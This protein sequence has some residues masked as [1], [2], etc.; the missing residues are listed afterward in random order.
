MK[1]IM[2]S[3]VVGAVLGAVAVMSDDT[4]SMD[5]EQFRHLKDL[6]KRVLSPKMLEVAK[7]PSQYPGF[8]RGLSVFS[9]SDP[10]RRKL[11]ATDE[12]CGIFLAASLS[13]NMWDCY[14]MFTTVLNLV[15]TENCKTKYDFSQSNMQ[16]ICTNPCYGSVVKALTTMSEAGC[17]AS[18]VRQTCSECATNEKCVEDKCRPI[19][20]DDLLCECEDTCTDGACI[21]PKNIEVQLA[22]LGVNGYRTTMEYLCTT[23]PNTNDYCFAKIFGVLNNVDASNFCNVLEPIGCCVGT[24][25]SYVTDC[26]TSNSTVQT[27][28]GPVQLTDLQDFCP[29]VDFHTGCA[30]VPALPAGSCV[31]GYFLSGAWPTVSLSIVMVAMTA[32]TALASLYL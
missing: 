21:P 14:N 1:G 25:F 23:A 24:V 10:E 12:E 19:C 27:N 28:I 15:S 3:F 26:A 17:S 7:D 9:E 8:E 16:R 4:F 6:S 11:G 22:N 5:K 18:A 13:A 31:E 20:N 32:A 29:T 2:R 30:N